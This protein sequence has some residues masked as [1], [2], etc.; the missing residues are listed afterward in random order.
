MAGP[1][2]FAE[3]LLFAQ[4]FSN[5]SW[6]ASTVY[7]LNRSLVVTVRILFL[8]LIFSCAEEQVSLHCMSVTDKSVITMSLSTVRKST[9]YVTPSM[10]P[11]M[12]TSDK[13]QT[14][15]TV[16]TLWFLE[17][18]VSVTFLICS[19]FLEILRLEESVLR[20]P[21]E[22]IGSSWAVPSQH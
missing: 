20:H 3:K 21:G 15:P 1:P 9:Q 17:R 16:A 13:N 4:T 8:S 18:V 2:T 19:I 5:I 6:P 12:Q 11:I 14:T 22:L 10:E 7:W